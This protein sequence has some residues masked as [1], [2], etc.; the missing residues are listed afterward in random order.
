MIATGCPKGGVGVQYPQHI[1]SGTCQIT[2]PSHEL[3]S[4]HG[5]IHFTF[6][7]VAA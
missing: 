1:R 6:P 2:W 4:M 3:L 5:C 7:I